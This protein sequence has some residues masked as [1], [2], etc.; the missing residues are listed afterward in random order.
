M[1]GGDGNYRGERAERGKEIGRGVFGNVTRRPVTL[2][3][4]GLQDPWPGLKDETWLDFLVYQSGHGTD[5]KKW[6]WQIEEMP[7]GAVLEPPRPVIDSEP[8]Y[9]AHLAYR[10]SQLITDASVRRAA[11]TSLLG[12]PVAGITY[13]AHGV[14]PWLR[15]REAP[16]NH[17]NSGEGDP[18]PVCLQYPGAA[19]MKVLRDV[20]DRLEWWTLRPAPEIVKDNPVDAEYSNV[21]MAAKTAAGSEALVYIPAGAVVFLDLSGWKVPLTGVWV[22]PRTGAAQEPVPLKPEAG[23]RLNLPAT[24]DW[25]LH[26][27]S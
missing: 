20:F 21:I 13:G 24:G 5:A 27:K 3:T 6:K 10:T 1:L 22:D 4:G 25:L 23:T 17:P 16:L 11:Y 15:K 9:E 26:L 19:Q 12:M 8:N 7:K 2:H 14:W 18:V